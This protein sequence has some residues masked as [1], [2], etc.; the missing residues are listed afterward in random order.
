MKAEVQSIYDFNVR[1]REFKI[2]INTGKAGLKEKIS[3]ILKGWRAKIKSVSQ[4]S[5]KL[6]GLTVTTTTII[7]S[8]KG[9]IL[10]QEK[11][12]GQM[13]FP[14]LV[15]SGELINQ[16]NAVLPH[17]PGVFCASCKVNQAE[18]H[19]VNGEEEQKLCSACGKDT[20]Y[21]MAIDNSML[22]IVNDGKTKDGIIKLLV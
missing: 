5:L 2:V 1:T 13:G 3:K 11:A 20:L 12:I 15:N 10:V 19:L 22:H 16:I 21:D 18:I 14:Y 4:A 17:L 8:A 9:S 6:G 7:V